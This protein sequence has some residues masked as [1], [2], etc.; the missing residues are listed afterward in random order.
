[1]AAASEGR[2]FLYSPLIDR[3][4]LASR[5]AGGLIDRLFGPVYYRLLLTGAE[6]SDEYLWELVTTIPATITG[7]HAAESPSDR[8]PP[9]PA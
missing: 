1:M 2:R 4:A 8:L 7:P 5:R 9:L 6:T 3:E